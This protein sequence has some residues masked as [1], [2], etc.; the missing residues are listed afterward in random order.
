MEELWNSTLACKK[1][2]SSTSKGYSSV[3]QKEK[4]KKKNREV[5]KYDAVSVKNNQTTKQKTLKCGS[6]DFHFSF[7]VCTVG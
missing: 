1:A 5:C 6:L 3:K 2:C 7:F 4:R